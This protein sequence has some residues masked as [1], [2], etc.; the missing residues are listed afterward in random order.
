M[1]E[2]EW[3]LELKASANKKALSDEKAYTNPVKQLSLL[4]LSALPD[5]LRNVATFTAL[6][7]QQIC[8]TFL[9]EC[10]SV[11]MFFGIFFDSIL[12]LFG[13]V[14]DLINE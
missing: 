9:C 14:F 12:D 7:N 8:F 3:F 6:S 10:E 13:R 11:E 1:L 2:F 4:R 5:Y